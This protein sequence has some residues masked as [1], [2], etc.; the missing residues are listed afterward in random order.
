V[1][2]ASLSSKT[3]NEVLKDPECF[4]FL[5]RFYDGLC[6]WEED[7]ATPVLHIGW[8]KPM[9]SSCSKFEAEVRARVE[10]PKDEMDA[11]ED[12]EEGTDDDEGRRLRKVVPEED[13]ECGGSRDG[14]INNNYYKNDKMMVQS[15]RNF[16]GET[17]CDSVSKSRSSSLLMCDRKSN[18]VSEE[19]ILGLSEGCKENVLN[20]DYLLGRRDCEPFLMLDSLTAQDLLRNPLKILKKK[21]L[22]RRRSR[23]TKSPKLSILFSD[24]DQSQKKVSSSGNSVLLHLHSVKMRGLKSLLCAEKLNASAIQLQLTAQSQ[25]QT[26]GP[27]EASGPGIGSG[28][29]EEGIMASGRPKRAR[30]E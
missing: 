29:G 8:A 27:K 30:R 7:S 6:C 26:R 3:Y 18:F 20:V 28:L 14:I 22:L 5:L 11:E 1:K 4:A 9:V 19:L 24:D 23:T 21:N 25:T 13:V 2:S 16:T 17:K 10:I 15:T 12:D